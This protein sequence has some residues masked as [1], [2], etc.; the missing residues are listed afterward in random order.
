MTKS[1]K[2]KTKKKVGRPKEPIKQKIESTHFDF[3]KIKKL[4][5]CGLID[6]DFAKVFGVDKATWTR[7]KKQDVEFMHLLKNGKELADKNMEQSLYKRGMGYQYQEVT[8]EPDKDGTLRISKRVIK[9][10][11]PDVGAI[12]FWLKNRQPD[13]WKERIANTTELPNE[14][15]EALR[16]L[17]QKVMA[18]NI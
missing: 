2:A 14:E 3:V 1:R 13:K 7:W 4:A 12:A 11:S 5:E 17:A 15:I 18:D 16:K 8:Q 10:V 9:E 6:E